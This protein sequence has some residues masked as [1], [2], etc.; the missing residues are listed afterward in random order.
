MVRQCTVVSYRTDGAFKFYDVIDFGAEKSALQALRLGTTETQ[1]ETLVLLNRIS[2][3]SPCH[4][5]HGH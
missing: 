1:L 5:H 2:A 3:E 4:C